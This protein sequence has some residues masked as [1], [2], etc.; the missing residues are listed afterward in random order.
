MRTP[1]R[2][3]IA[4]LLANALFAGPAAA[5]PPT[6]SPEVAKALGDVLADRIRA[7][8]VVTLYRISPELSSRGAHLGGYPILRELRLDQSPSDAAKVLES[9]LDA[10]NYG[11][12]VAKC[13]IP[14]HAIRLRSLDGVFTTLVLCFECRQMLWVEQG[15]TIVL[16]E[17][18]PISDLLE[19]LLPSADAVPVEA[20]KRT[21]PGK[22]GAIPY[23]PEI[24]R[25]LTR[26]DKVTVYRIRP[27]PS[28][29][30]ERIEG[31]PIV[32]KKVL[33]QELAKG[34]LAALNDPA[35]YG[36]DFALCFI[37]HHALRLEKGGEAVALIVCFECNYLQVTPPGDGPREIAFGAPKPLL[38]AIEA[39]LTGGM[40]WEKSFDLAN[41]AIRKGNYVQCRTHFEQGLA[42]LDS[43]LD[44]MTPEARIRRL[45]E[46]E[47]SKRLR[48]AH[49]NL[50]CVY[51]LLSIGKESPKGTPRPLPAAEAARLRGDAFQQ[52]H[53]A[54]DRGWDEAQK[55]RSDT[56]LAPLRS[57]ARWEELMRRFDR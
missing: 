38:S 41:E 1:S 21:S 53:L 13:F 4:C 34:L 40:D 55:F 52:L 42:F 46:P 27:E 47:L 37:P 10:R 24:A 35:T 51:A 15:S 54:I 14:H 56:D 18:P 22:P 45:T 25:L 48:I 50:A 5:A 19:L 16:A 43:L 36:G 7:A 44:G 12:E 20:P 3:A 17:A 30:G 26:P 29:E 28:E 39:A 31:Y 49:Y 33:S 9:L 11:T 32:E 8:E 2:I 6:P 57:D 23:A